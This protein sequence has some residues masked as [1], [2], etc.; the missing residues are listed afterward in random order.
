MRIPQY[1]STTYAEARQKFLQAARARGGAIETYV[2]PNAEGAEGE[3]L[4]A[5]V[6]RFGEMDAGNLFVVISGTHGNEGFCGSGCQTGFI[7]EGVIDARPKSVALVM[8]HAINPYGFSHIRRVTEDNAALNRNFRDFSEAL[9]KNPR[10]AE[11]HDLLLPSDWDGPGRASADAALKA[12]RDANGGMKAFQAAVVAGQYAYPD[13]LFFGGRKPTWSNQTFRAIVKK[14]GAGAKRVGVID[15]HSGLGPAGYGEPL[16]IVAPGAP[17]F[18]RARAWWGDEVTSTVDGTSKSPP[19]TGPLI[20]SVDESLPGAEV[21]AIGLEYGTI[22]L[23]EL[24]DALRGDNWLYA[25]G[26]K[27]GLSIDSAL[28]RDIKAKVRDALTIDTDA[29]KEKVFARAADFTLKAFRGL[30]G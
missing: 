15:F 4:A 18:E 22:E 27:S 3:E 28:A 7:G 17:A 12:W 9:P 10:Y 11:I 24:L 23:S 21:T 29:W 2:N 8:A 13:G 14:H 25:R 16:S 30:S 6:A 20:G 1:F 19:V 5:D 26:L